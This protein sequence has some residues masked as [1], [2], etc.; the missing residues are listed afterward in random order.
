LEP[1]VESVPNDAA[2]NLYLGVVYRALGEEALAEERFSQIPPATLAQ[3][4][5]HL[6]AADI[7]ERAGNFAAAYAAYCETIRLAGQWEI[8]LQGAERNAAALNQ[9]PGC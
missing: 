7:Y 4:G 6:F 1:V 2:A 8:A 5:F 9:D 3:P